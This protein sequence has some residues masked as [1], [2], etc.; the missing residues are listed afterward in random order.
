MNK[1]NPYGNTPK[2]ELLEAAK[3]LQ[4]PVDLLHCAR[5]FPFINIL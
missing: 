2:N 3:Q 4:V 1:G 5:M